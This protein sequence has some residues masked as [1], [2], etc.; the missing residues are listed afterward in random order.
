MRYILLEMLTR[1][2]HMYTNTLAS[3][4]IGNT[5][6][7][8]CIGLIHM[9]RV[10]LSILGLNTIKWM[11]LQNGHGILQPNIVNEEKFCDLIV[12]LQYQVSI[13]H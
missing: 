5:E 13:Q 12:I 10:P 8:Q 4:C 3:F 11:L 7:G 9:K 2:I 1:L 6:R